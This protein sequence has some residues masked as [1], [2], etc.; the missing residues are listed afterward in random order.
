MKFLAKEI[1]TSRDRKE[2]KNVGEEELL[3]KA[4]LAVP[5]SPQTKPASDKIIASKPKPSGF[6]PSYIDEASAEERLEVEYLLDFAFHHGI[7]QAIK[8]SKKSPDFIQDAF[9][10]SL[11]KLLAPELKRRGVLK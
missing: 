9:H 4:M 5:L 6:L 3:K 1:A 10:D 2:S 7:A 11:V 8:E